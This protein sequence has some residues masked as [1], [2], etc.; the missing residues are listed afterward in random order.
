MTRHR[1]RGTAAS[2]LLLA[3]VS[4]AEAADVAVLKSSEVAAWRPAL[5]ALRRSA[6]SHNITEY[7]LR[8]D[9]AAAEQVLGSLKGKPVV[10]VAMG[11]LAAQAAR[12]ILP[13]APLVFCMVQDPPK[14][15]LVPGPNLTGVAFTL[16]VKN[17]IAA[18]RTVHPRASRIGVVFNPANSGH[19]VEEADKAAG[20]LRIALFP[21]PVASLSEIP[22][23]LRTLLSGD[24]VDAIWILADPILLSDATRRY[25]LT[26]SLKAGKPVYAFS[27]SLVAEGALVSNGP[28]LASIGQQ[29]GELVNRL[30]AGDRSRI[31]VQTPRAE[32]VINN[33][34][35]GK[36]KIVVPAD[37]LKAANKV[38]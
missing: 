37:V 22:Q 3:A 24:T 1:R 34:I 38:M 33:R 23:A 32:L 28:D 30:A 12:A 10:L 13:E 6:A 11:N 36:L 18:F 31:D 14:L 16:P 21:R 8:G 5:D 35:A 29:A 15:G 7:D 2:L 26:E 9:R 27:A 19:Q 17:Q 4:A 25:I 20:L